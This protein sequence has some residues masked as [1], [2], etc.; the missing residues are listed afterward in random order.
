MSL[1]K[2]SHL[3]LLFCANL[4][5]TIKFKKKQLTSSFESASVEVLKSIFPYN[6]EMKVFG[7][8]NTEDKSDEWK[9]NKLWDKLQ[10]LANFMNVNL[11]VKKRRY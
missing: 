2:Q 7:S 10:W 8:S 4:K 1:K 6:T 11:L 9:S 5:Y 3:F